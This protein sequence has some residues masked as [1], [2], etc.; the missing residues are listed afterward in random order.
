MEQSCDE[1]KELRGIDASF[2]RHEPE[3]P[4]GGDGGNHVQSEAAPGARHHRRLPL[5]APGGAG[6]M[7]GAQSRL[8]AWEDAG[9]HGP[10]QLSYPGILLVEPFLHRL[11]LLLVGPPERTLGGESE[12]IQKTAYR[13]LAEGDAE[14][15]GDR[16][17]DHLR[18]PEGKGK[19]ELEGIFHRDRIVDPLHRGS[20]EPGPA[21][22]PF[23]RIEVIPSPL[24]DRASQ[25]YMAWR[26]SGDAGNDLRAFA[27]LHAHDCPFSEFRQRPVVKSSGIHGSL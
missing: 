9:L 22:S 11:G 14:A 4:L 5:H 27:L 23:L 26:L 21:A 3:L 10:G 6:M 18:G 15:F 17:T 24:A 25:P 16:L 7:V 12:L 1:L 20:V 19:L 13:G 8:I 2:D